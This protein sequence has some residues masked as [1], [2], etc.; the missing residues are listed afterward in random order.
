M[1]ARLNSSFPVADR[2]SIN[3]VRYAAT[4]GGV[5]PTGA[6]I[7]LA[8]FSI[9]TLLTVLIVSANVANLMLSRA[10]ARQRETAI[11]QSLGASR[12]RI[13]RLLLAEG[14]SISVVAWL[15]ACLMTVWAARAIPRLMPESP[16]AQSG[17]DFSP[18]WRVVAY[19]MVL[20]AIGT[21]AFSLAP[22]LRVWHQDALPWLKAAS[23]VSRRENRDC[24]M[25]LVVLQLAFSVVL[26]TVAGTG[27]S[28][29]VAH[30][31]GS[32]L[33]L[34]QSAPADGAHD[35]HRDDSRHQPRSARSHRGAVQEHSRCPAG[36]LC[37]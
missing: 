7:F 17:L 8:I 11:R 1:Q 25:S 37:P 19:A 26:L 12:F 33:R 34:E 28:F 15:A 24:P 20:A 32:W 14:L 2:P 30:D 16:F 5:I 3:V 27:H 10:V 9:V 21:I 13:V 29:G 18:D 36:F 6:P 22:A 35:R 4:A 31:G 23:T